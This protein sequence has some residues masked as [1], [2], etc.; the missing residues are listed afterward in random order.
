MVMQYFSILAFGLFQVHI[1]EISCMKS[2]L[3]LL[4]DSSNK[5][6]VVLK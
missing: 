1:H 2:L 6:V 3:L 5:E 4:R